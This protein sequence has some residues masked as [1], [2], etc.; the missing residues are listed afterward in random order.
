[1]NSYSFPDHI[2]INPQG[3]DLI[4]K[5]LRTDPGKRLS[6]EQVLDH[7]FLLSVP[8]SMPTSTLACPPSSSI[9]QQFGS[10]GTGSIHSVATSRRTEFKVR[11]PGRENQNGEL[12]CVK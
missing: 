6:L 10:A 3:K 12:V 11:S 5:L 2:P 8:E 9:L 4:S 7:E 1:M